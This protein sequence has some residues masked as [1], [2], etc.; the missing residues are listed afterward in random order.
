[1]AIIILAIAAWTW[2]RQRRQRLLREQR[3]GP[4]PE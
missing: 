2:R 1:M 3:H 4:R